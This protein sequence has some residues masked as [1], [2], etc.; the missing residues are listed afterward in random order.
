[1]L[2]SKP[3]P[4]LL[5]SGLVALLGFYMPATAAPAFDCGEE[6]AAV[7]TDRGIVD[8]SV[9]IADSP[10]E[11]AQGLMFRKA[12]PRGNGMLFVYDAPREVAFWMRNTL[13]PLDL[14]FMDATGTIRHIHPNARPL[15][16]TPIPGATTD[17]PNP[18][19]KLILEIPGGE[20]ARLGLAAGQPMASLQIDQTKAAWRCR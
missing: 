8:F 15:D 20:A 4:S 17:D 5:F 2:P 10:E 16:E 7:L 19:R 3:A 6:R 12:L 9:E 11:R 13:I 1:M 18:E 14:V